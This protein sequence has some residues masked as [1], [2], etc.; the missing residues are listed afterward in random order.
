MVSFRKIAS[1]TA[2]IAVCTVVNGQ[3]IVNSIASH[4]SNAI[5]SAR[6]SNVPEAQARSD[7]GKMMA[8][9][10]TD[11]RL[12]AYFEAAIQ[13]A[14]H[15]SFDT[16]VASAYLT[17]IGSV[18]SSVTR[19]PDFYTVANRARRAAGDYDATAIGSEAM[20]EVGAFAIPVYNKI[21]SLASEDLD[22]S[23][24]VSS[25]SSDGFAVASK[26]FFNGGFGFGNFEVNLDAEDDVRAYIADITDYWVKDENNKNGN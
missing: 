16:S 25:L 10:T 5:V 22:I 23:S 14:Q 13:T 15:S 19:K 1:G 20:K 9:V 12:S 6:H 24:L 4:M 21:N 8:F 26:V 17:N 3:H 7:V 18:I 11:N 2:V